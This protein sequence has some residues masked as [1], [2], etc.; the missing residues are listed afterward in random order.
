MQ[1]DCRYFSGATTS[2]ALFSKTGAH[3]NKGG[4]VCEF[5]GGSVVFLT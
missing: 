1:Y 2:P 5:Y 4:D 3:P